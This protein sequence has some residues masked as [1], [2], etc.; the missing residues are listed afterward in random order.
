MK[1]VP[2]GAGAA[3][4]KRRQEPAE[5]GEFRRAWYGPHGKSLARVAIVLRATAVPCLSQYPSPAA[6]DD[7]R[8]LIR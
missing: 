2:T 6:W 3:D 1:I 4:A 8:F 5:R 7:A